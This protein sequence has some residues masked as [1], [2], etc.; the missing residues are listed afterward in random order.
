MVDKYRIGKRLRN[1][2]YKSVSGE[3][4]GTPKE[5][6]GFRAGAQRG[7]STSIALAFIAANRRIFELPETLEGLEVKRVIRSLGAHHVILG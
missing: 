4:Y 3:Y 5:V 6:W 2:A 7:A 1:G